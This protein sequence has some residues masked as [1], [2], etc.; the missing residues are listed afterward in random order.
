MM[1]ENPEDLFAVID[2]YKKVQALIWGHIHQ[3]FRTERRGV[4][5]CGSPSTCV[6]FK[7][8]SENYATDD[9]GPGYSVLQLYRN[10]TFDINTQ[11][12]EENFSHY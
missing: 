4:I 1:L 2:K 10:G 8:C 12:P 3:E 5:L 9:L 7:P 6:Q 11:R